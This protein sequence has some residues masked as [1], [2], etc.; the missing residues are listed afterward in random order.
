MYRSDYCESRLRTLHDGNYAESPG[1][2]TITLISDSWQLVTTTLSYNTFCQATS[3]NNEIK[4]GI[5][6]DAVIKEFI[7]VDPSSSDAL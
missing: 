6:G 4:I 5:N 1:F 3:M 7:V 2:A